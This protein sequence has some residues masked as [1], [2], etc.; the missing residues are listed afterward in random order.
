MKETNKK[1]SNS[2]FSRFAVIFLG[3]VLL[4]WLI[5]DIITF[6]V[7]GNLTFWVILV[8]EFGLGLLC[9][10]YYQRYQADKILTRDNFWF[11]PAFIVGIVIPVAI[12]NLAPDL[13]PINITLLAFFLALVAAEV[14]RKLKLR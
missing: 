3:I 13:G 7:A 1:P 4:G 9:F 14:Y 5:G 10:M 6:S 11:A 2:S 8:V 12:N